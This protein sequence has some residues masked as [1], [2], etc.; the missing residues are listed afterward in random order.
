M[1]SAST[2]P[3]FKRAAGKVEKYPNVYDSLAEAKNAA[4][5]FKFYQQ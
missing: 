4:C 3:I 5:K 1:V 2:L